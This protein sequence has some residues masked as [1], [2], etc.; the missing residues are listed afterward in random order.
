MRK[1]NIYLDD[2]R[3]GVTEHIVITNFDKNTTVNDL[4]ILVFSEIFNNIK[5][6]NDYN[7][8]SSKFRLL[9]ITKK[10]VS[11]RGS[12]ILRIKNSLL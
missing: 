8:Y 10:L 2:I 3:G 12:L 7:L 6:I 1:L 4:L 11:V 9:P 5:I